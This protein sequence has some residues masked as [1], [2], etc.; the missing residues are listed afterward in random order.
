MDDQK[1]RLIVHANEPQDDVSRK[2]TIVFGPSAAAEPLFA[3]ATSEDD[4]PSMAGFHIVTIDL[5]ETERTLQNPYDV[6]HELK[7]KGRFDWVTP[8]LTRN[9]DVS[10]VDLSE[11]C[12]FASAGDDWSYST[13]NLVACRR[14]NITRHIYV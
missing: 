1:L 12:G 5:A 13:L 10:S 4:H 9:P 3:G 6:A 8:D 7:Q 14:V 11:L 2:A